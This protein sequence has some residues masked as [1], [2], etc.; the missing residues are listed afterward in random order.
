MLEVS[1]RRSIGLIVT[2]VLVAALLLGI[3]AIV[4]GGETKL[5]RADIGRIV[6]LPHGDD[7]QV[8][9]DGPRDAPAI[10]LL[11]GFASSLH[12]WDAIT[13]ALASRYHV[14]RFDLLGNG[15]SAKPSGGYSMEHEAQLVA[16]ALN[17]L[18]V[19]RALLVGHSMGGLVAT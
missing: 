2:L 6:D 1:K 16:E 13:P 5:A 3:N 12:W 14:I 19:R 10:V 4:V 9:E 7:L 15:G 17:Q 18:G 11:H 8:R